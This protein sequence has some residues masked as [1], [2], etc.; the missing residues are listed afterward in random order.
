MESHENL[1]EK[2]IWLLLK[3]SYV[4]TIVFAQIGANSDIDVKVCYRIL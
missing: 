3:H 4:N 1:L 2:Y